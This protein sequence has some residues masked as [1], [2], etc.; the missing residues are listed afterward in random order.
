LATANYDISTFAG[1]AIPSTYLEF[2]DFADTSDISKVSRSID[3]S[4]FCINYPRNHQD[5]N[6]NCILGR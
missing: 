4:I 2:C 5:D 1:V 3:I 6:D